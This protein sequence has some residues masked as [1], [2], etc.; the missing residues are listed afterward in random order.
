MH[1]AIRLTTPDVTDEAID[2][3]VKA[4]KYVKWTSEAAPDQRIRSRLEGAM[5]E[6]LTG[7]IK[8]IREAEGPTYEEWK[9]RLNL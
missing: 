6:D 2:R 9:Q 3:D 8:S 4:G 5:G 7:S 1:K